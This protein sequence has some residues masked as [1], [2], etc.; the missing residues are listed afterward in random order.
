LQGGKVTDNLAG[1]IIRLLAR[2][3]TLALPAGRLLR[4][5]GAATNRPGRKVSDD[6]VAGVKG[7]KT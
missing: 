2:A 4:A 1:G 3:K 6:L 5:C 7:R